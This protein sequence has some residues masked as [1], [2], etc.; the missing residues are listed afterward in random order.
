MGPWKF[1]EAILAGREFTLYDEGRP[2]RDWTFISDIV[3][4]SLLL[5]TRTCS[6]KYSTWVEASQ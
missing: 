1:T 5:R 2:R 3:S 4:A 6:T